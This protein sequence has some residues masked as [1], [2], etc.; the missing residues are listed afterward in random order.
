MASSSDLH[1]NTKLLQGSAAVSVGLLFLKQVTSALHKSAVDPDHSVPTKPHQNQF[2]FKLKDLWPYVLQS[3]RLRFFFLQCKHS[4]I[5]HFRL[6]TEFNDKSKVLA[7]ELGFD[8]HIM[9]TFNCSHLTL[10]EMP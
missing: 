7:E 2:K 4:S 3:Q 1:M 5:C 9:V 10:D 8:Y 6:C